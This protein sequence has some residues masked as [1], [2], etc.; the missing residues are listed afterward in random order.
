MI[1]DSIVKI[2]E[3]IARRAHE[4]QFRRD[5]VT[6]YI[7]HVEAVVSRIRTGDPRH[8]AIAWLHDVVEDTDVSADD[9]LA[10]GIPAEVVQAVLSLT[11]RQGESYDDYLTRALANDLA[12]PVKL[13]DLLSNLSDNPT[14]K[15]IRK[16]AAALLRV[17]PHE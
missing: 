15:Q 4:G 12:I 14:R 1:M 16:Y 3:S 17:V 5:G 8:L 6:P 9:L 10:A 11:V 2:A 7:T 13:A